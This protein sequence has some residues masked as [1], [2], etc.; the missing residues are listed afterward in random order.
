[1]KSYENEL[2]LLLKKILENE[3]IIF[4]DIDEKF[5]L[6]IITSI[7][8]FLTKDYKLV[9]ILLC[10]SRPWIYNQKI[11]V[12]KKISMESVYFI[13]CVKCISGSVEKLFH[14]ENHV[15]FL[16]SPFDTNEIFDTISKKIKIIKENKYIIIDDLA[17]MLLYWDKLQFENFLN[18]IK[19]LNTNTIILVPK[20][21]NV[22]EIKKL[23][24]ELKR[25]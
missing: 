5:T 19:T 9:C 23:K 25:C 10:L 6:K 21:C 13:D 22:K 12:L 7:V 24:N 4:F 16:K 14:P 3:K 20:I 11:L 2:Q 15:S 8:E 18:K 1:M 17:S